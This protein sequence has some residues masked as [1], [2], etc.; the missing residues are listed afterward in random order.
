MSGCSAI[1]ADGERCRG[2]AAAQSDYCPAHDPARAE[3]RHKA[4]SKAARS[5]PSRE[6]LKIKGLLR[7]LYSDVLAG[8][9]EPKAAA[10]AGQVANTQLRAIELERRMREAEELE[11]RLGEVEELLEAA[12]SRTAN[13]RW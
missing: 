6:L 8:R 9:V 2:I 1:K 12:E 13:G 3:E 4:A 7:E 5:K 10:V 11:A